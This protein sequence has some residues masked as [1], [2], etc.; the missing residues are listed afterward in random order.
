MSSEQSYNDDDFIYVDPRNRTSLGVVEWKKEGV[1]VPM[2]L[3]ELE[4]KEEV[5]DT[6]GKGKK[7]DKKDDGRR[8]RKPRKRYAPWGSYRSM[9][10]VYRLEG[11]KEDDSGQAEFNDVIVRFEE[12]PM[13]V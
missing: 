12:D 11:K 6:K 3:P 4:Q 7:S 13:S 9:N 10:K 1:A 2:E 8:K 5:S